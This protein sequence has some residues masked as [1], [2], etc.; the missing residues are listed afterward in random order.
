MAN[1]E[2]RATGQAIPEW[3]GW[4]RRLQAG[5][6]PFVLLNEVLEW[7]RKRCAA[8]TALLLLPVASG[9]EV[10]FVL[11]NGQGMEELHGLRLRPEETVL[12]E[13][14]Q[15]R[16]PW[17]YHNAGELEF[18]SRGVRRGFKG[19]RSGVG[20]PLPGIS[21]SAL[22]LVNRRAQ[23]PFTDEDEALL[24]QLAPFFALGVHLYALQQTLQRRT[25]ALES[26]RQL[27]QIQQEEMSLQRVLQGVE[28]VLRAVSP[29]AGGLWLYDEERRQLFCTLQYGA[30]LLPET[31][32]PSTLPH[33]WQHTPCTTTTES[34]QAI[35][36]FPLRL[37]GRTLGMLMSVGQ[38]W[39]PAGEVSEPVDPDLL[40]IISEHVALLV[41]YALQQEQLASRNTLF[42]TF[43]E[44][45]LRLGEVRTPEECLALLA[46]NAMQL[47]P[48]DYCVIY[49]ATGTARLQPVWVS[50]PDETLQKH[51]PDAQYSLPGWVCAFNAPLAAPDLARHPQNLKEPLPQKFQSALAVPLQVAEQ[52][53]GTLLLLTT[54]PREFT[55]AEVE[56]LF[57]LANFG[58]LHLQTIGRLT[59]A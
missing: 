26:M 6:D 23:E 19:L 58:A 38:G 47:V 1:H 14:L 30:S 53:F 40:L 36:L 54:T 59:H 15:K 42:A 4:L 52:A 21:G 5:T 24:A 43:Y 51:Y 22:V 44:F 20:V 11:V 9:Q 57:M 2:Q 16:L 25:H 12:D 35:Q 7:A 33:D 27:S 37:A 56:A 8:Q 28:R 55:L 34:G 46:Q 29:F 48:T 39:E 31:I 50:P 49:F 17:R 32:D 10:E 41:G 13:L 3:D 45:S 18:H